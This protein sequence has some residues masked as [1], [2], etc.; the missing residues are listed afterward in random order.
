MGQKKYQVVWWGIRD[1]NFGFVRLDPKQTE[2]ARVYV[3]FLRLGPLEI[4]KWNNTE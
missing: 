1:M 4:R 2:M 3:W